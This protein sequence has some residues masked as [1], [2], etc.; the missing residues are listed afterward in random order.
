MLLIVH[1]HAQNARHE[2]KCAA[3]IEELRVA[4][5]ESHDA[6]YTLDSANVA[7]AESDRFTDDLVADALAAEE[8]HV[9]G[10]PASACAP[11]VFCAC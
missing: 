4:R 2:S 6:H 5:S 8:I 9:S 11:N 3:L 7:R 10:L 1:P